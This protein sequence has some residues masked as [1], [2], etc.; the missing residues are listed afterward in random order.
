MYGSGVR[1]CVI[2]EVRR[3]GVWIWG[4]GGRED[5]EGGAVVVV[6]VVVGV[7]A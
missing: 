2:I 5:W 4:R 7:D 3:V 6:V 1:E